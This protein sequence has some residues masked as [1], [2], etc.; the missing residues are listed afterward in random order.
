MVTA[1]SPF[2]IKKMHTK[3]RRVKLHVLFKETFKSKT[4][5]MYPELFQ[6]LRVNQARRRGSY[7][8]KGN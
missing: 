4:V 3:V 1:M 2:V 5:S 7:N 6:V 8:I